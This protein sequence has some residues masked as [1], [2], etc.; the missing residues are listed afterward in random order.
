MD[1]MASPNVGDN[2]PEASAE[3]AEW[4]EEAAEWAAVNRD[5]IVSIRARIPAEQFVAACARAGIDTKKIMPCASE[6]LA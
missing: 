2:H 1:R 6:L 4:A 5:M 3:W